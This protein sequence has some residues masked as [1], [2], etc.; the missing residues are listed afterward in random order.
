LV[1]AVAGACRSDELCKM[2]VADVNIKDDMIVINIPTSKMN[3]P[4]SLS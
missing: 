4:E 1:I 2:L 3:R